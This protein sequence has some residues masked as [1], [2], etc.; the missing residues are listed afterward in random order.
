MP[1]LCEDGNE[2]AGS[3]KAICDCSSEK[4]CPKDTEYYEYKTIATHNIIW[5]CPMQRICVPKRTADRVLSSSTSITSRGF[6]S[7]V[8][9]QT[10]TV[11]FA[12]SR[13]NTEDNDI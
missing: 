4:S 12:L 1:G 10:G 3:L 11:I 13:A 5:K 9:L 6:I 7:R 2:P 8:E